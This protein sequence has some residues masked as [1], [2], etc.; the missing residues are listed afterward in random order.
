M[1]G[2]GDRKGLAPPGSC[3]RI[4]G[5]AMFLK[6]SHFVIPGNRRLFSLVSVIFY[7]F[8]IVFLIVPEKANVGNITLSYSSD[9]PLVLPNVF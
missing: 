1:F 8:R 2:F 7:S 4:S 3:E 6:C 5:N 9:S